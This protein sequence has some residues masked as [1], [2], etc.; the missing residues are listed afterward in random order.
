MKYEKVVEGIFIKRPN[1]FIAH[2]YINGIEEI[3][4][5]RNTGR[6]RELLIPGAKVIL[7]DCSNNPNRKTKYSLLKSQKE[8]IFNWL[9]ESYP[10]YKKNHLISP[11]SPKGEAFSTR[12]IVW[13]YILLQKLHLENAFLWVYSKL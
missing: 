13:I 12:T 4:H 10:S 7:E 11:F 1:R 3:V 9:K 8:D 6:C 5:V 2:V